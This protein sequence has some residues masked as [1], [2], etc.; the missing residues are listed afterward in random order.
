M[1]IDI[2]FVCLMEEAAEVQ[3]AVS[4]LIRFGSNNHNP[5]NP[6]TTNSEDIMIE[7]YQLQAVMEL[8]Q[9][10]GK[11]PILTTDEIRNIKKYKKRKL[12]FF[13]DRRKEHWQE[14]HTKP[15]YK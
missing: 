9:E 3:Q 14:K 15:R 1:Q 4:K 5:K 11:L 8:L 12:K 6:E 13:E 7:Y 10:K 2:L